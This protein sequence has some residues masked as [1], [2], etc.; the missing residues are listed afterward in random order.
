MCDHVRPDLVPVQIVG[1]DQ[2]E[3]VPSQIPQPIKV[4]LVYH[5]I[6]CLNRA[7]V[8]LI[9]APVQADLAVVQPAARRCI[10]NQ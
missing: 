7:R 4:Y 3:S 10:S 8:T 1:L 2:M 5:I 6:A 9:R